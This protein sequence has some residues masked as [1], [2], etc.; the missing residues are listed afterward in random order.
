MTILLTVGALAEGLPPGAS[1][2]GYII[3]GD[4]EPSN[5]LSID[6]PYPAGAT[7][8]LIRGTTATAS[9]SITIS[10]DNKW[11]LEVADA[12]GT[13]TDSP[14]RMEEYESEAYVASGADLLSKLEILV[15]G[16]GDNGD[17]TGVTLTDVEG[18]N[19]LS[20]I[21]TYRTFAQSDNTA[22]GLT[23]DLEY[24]QPVASNDPLKT[25]KIDLI[26]QLSYNI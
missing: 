2:D 8:S 1:A 4:F 21:N 22:S 23:V 13:N 7:L 5:L 17:L 25:Y 24:S 12:G 6:L 20:D 11:K 19:D 15:D 3:L 16:I 9:D 18:T 14:G 26:Y 10:S